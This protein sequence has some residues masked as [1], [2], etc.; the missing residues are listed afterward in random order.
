MLTITLDESDCFAAWV[1]AK[2]A[3]FSS[4]DGSDPKRKIVKRS[5]LTVLS[6]ASLLTSS[7]P[8]SLK[9]TWAGCCS[10]LSWSSGPE[11]AST[12]WTRKRTK[13][14]TVRMSSSTN[15]PPQ[16][17]ELGRRCF[18]SAAGGSAVCFTPG[19]CSSP[20]QWTENRRTESRRATDTSKC[21]RTHRSFLEKQEAEL[22]LG[23]PN[24]LHPK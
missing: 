15:A 20:L 11:L 8:T 12:P 21:P 10:R 24:Y 13:W 4:S 16:R 7:A 19:L 5:R 14:T 6:D 1:S 23:I 18:P 3:G 22:Y 9:W 17:W 2:D